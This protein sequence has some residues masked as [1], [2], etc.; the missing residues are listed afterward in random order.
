M[1]SAGTIL[2]GPLE[3]VIAAGLHDTLCDRRGV[4]F[5]TQTGYPLLEQAAAE[6]AAAVIMCRS[7]LELIDPHQVASRVVGLWTRTWDAL[8]VDCGRVTHLHNPSPRDVLDV[9]TSQQ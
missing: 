6:D 5:C 2:V 9:A 4:R 3:G 1:T 8:V 7:D